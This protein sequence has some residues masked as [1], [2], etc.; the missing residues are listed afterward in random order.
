MA[1]LIMTD[2]D[3][4]RW[5]PVLI[6]Y[7]E[8]KG[9]KIEET[10]E[11]IISVFAE[12]QSGW[13]RAPRDLDTRIKMK[14]GFQWKSH[15]NLNPRKPV[16]IEKED[17]EISEDLD[18][19]YLFSTMTKS[20]KLW[21]DD[22]NSIY[23]REFEFNDSSDR[24]LLDQL[25]VEELMQRRLFRKSLKYPDQDYNKK[26]NDSVKRVTDIQTK[27]GITR[28]QRAGILSKI[29]G[30]VAEMALSLDE[31]L[32]G[33]PEELKQQY[34]EELRFDVLRQQRPPINILPPIPKLEAL[35][36]LGGSTN[37]NLD[38]SEI[39]EITEQISK[40]ITEI[41]ETKKEL[42]NKELPGGVNL[43]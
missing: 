5:E 26:L 3:R 22:R 6:E 39:S 42:E 20:E 40:E 33:M 34:E 23:N 17:I 27:L 1:A 12:A 28:E 36:N 25:L 19:N 24:P 32:K 18:E 11:T 10:M 15:A 14:S 38:G 16:V 13:N 21:W 37:L 41:R 29:G 7:Y 4:R 43:S 8:T 31:K 9:L 35:L 30:N 2:E